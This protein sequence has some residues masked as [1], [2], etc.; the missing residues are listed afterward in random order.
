MKN[1]LYSIIKNQIPER[2]EKNQYPNSISW[3]LK[4]IKKQ[5]LLNS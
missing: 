1:R 5:N 3:G 2:T 4:L